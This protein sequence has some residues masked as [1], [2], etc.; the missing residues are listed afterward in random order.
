M[1][2]HHSHVHGHTPVLHEHADDWHHHDASEE[3]P[4]VEHGSMA[5]AATIMQWFVALIV[6]IVLFVGATW[7]YFTKYMTEVRIQKLEQPPDAEYQA[8]RTVTRERLT[9]PTPADRWLDAEHLRISINQ[10]QERVIRDYANTAPAAPSARPAAPASTP[11]T[12]AP[13]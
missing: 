6:T 12:P 3:V 10:A 5:S 8:Y 4:Q 2:D 1:T 7:M 11:P 13:R 9:A